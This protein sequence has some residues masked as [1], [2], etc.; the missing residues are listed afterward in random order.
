VYKTRENHF[1]VDS[2]KK[3][4][5]II[6]NMHIF[7]SWRGKYFSLQQISRTES[8]WFVHLL[9][10]VSFRSTESLIFMLK[11]VIFC[12]TQY[13]FSF[14][15]LSLY[16]MCTASQKFYRAWCSCWH[17]LLVLATNDDQ[18]PQKSCKNKV[19]EYCISERLKTRTVTSLIFVCELNRFYWTF[20][21]IKI[22]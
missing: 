14:L 6:N 5:L 20:I 22:N 15:Y 10:Y 19:S 8:V 2:N 17:S 7:N 13:I 11:D 18:P 16:I 12:T 4:N 9:R 3:H 21:K 1:K